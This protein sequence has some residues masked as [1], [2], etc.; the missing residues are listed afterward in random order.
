M[1]EKSADICADAEWRCG[2]WRKGA[3]LSLYGKIRNGLQ[4]SEGGGGRAE[5]ISIIVELKLKK[6][7]HTVESRLQII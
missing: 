4:F 2:I 7:Y 1:K 3:F 6:V 5:I